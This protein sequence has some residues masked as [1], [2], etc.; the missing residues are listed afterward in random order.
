MTA[1]ILGGS[2]VQ[3]GNSGILECGSLLPPWIGEACFA[4]EGASKL[5]PSKETNQGEFWQDVD[6]GADRSTYE[7]GRRMRYVVVPVFFH[8]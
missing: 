7:G 4:Q 6:S 5:A 8:P 3:Q 2:P 1:R